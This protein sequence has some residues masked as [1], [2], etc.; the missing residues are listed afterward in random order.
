MLRSK[1]LSQVRR[2]E[3]FLNC[4]VS[5]IILFIFKHKTIMYGAVNILIEAYSFYVSDSQVFYLILRGQ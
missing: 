1:Y 5:V 2:R 4:M 3:S